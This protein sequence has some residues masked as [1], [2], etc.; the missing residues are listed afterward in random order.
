MFEKKK[1]KKGLKGYMDG[2]KVCGHLKCKDI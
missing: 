1:K 2:K